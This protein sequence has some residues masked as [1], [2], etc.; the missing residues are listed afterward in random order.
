MEN[1]DIKRDQTTDPSHGSRIGMPE[2]G[3]AEFFRI[4]RG[5][6]AGFLCEVCNRSGSHQ[7]DA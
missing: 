5:W 7:D 4:W 3:D 2:Q 1:F 6:L